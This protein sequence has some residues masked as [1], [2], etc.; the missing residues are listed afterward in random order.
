[1]PLRNSL[2]RMFSVV[3]LTLLAGG[4]GGTAMKTV[5]PQTDPSK[6]RFGSMKAG[7]ALVLHLRDGRRLEI[8]VARLDDDAFV[9]AEGIRYPYSDI[10]QLQRRSF[11]V[12][13]TIGLAGG[14]YLG[15]AAAVAIALALLL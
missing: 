5:N 9:S 8:T 6:P 11:S 3:M 12:P 1:M 10:A 15:S 2:R 7:D 14:L 13:K 4:A